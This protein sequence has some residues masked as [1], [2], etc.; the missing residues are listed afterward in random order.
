MTISSRKLFG[1]FG[2]N[3]ACLAMTD[4]TGLKTALRESAKLALLSLIVSGLLVPSVVAENS[5]IAFV[6]VNVVPMDRERV[7]SNQTV[8]V[9]KGRITA[10]GAAD[11][12]SVPAGA[13]RVEG[14]GKFLTPGLAEMHAHIPDPNSP[15]FVNDVL[16]LF[17]AN[18][19][20]T[21]RGM[22]GIPGQLALKQ[23]ANK[24]EMISPTL[25]LAGPGFSGNPEYGSVKT[26]EQA[27]QQ[28]RQQKAEGWD[29]LKVLPGF[30]VVPYDAMARTAKEVGMRF[31]GH[32][33]DGRGGGLMHALEMGQETIEHMDGYVAYLNGNSGVNESALRDVHP[34]DEAA[35][36]EV[37]RKTREA[38]VWICP[39]MAWHE[40]ST[41]WLDLKAVSSRPEL[42]YMPPQ[43]V[44]Q[45]TTGHKKRLA[46]PQFKPAVA[47]QIVENRKRILKGLHDGG[48]R[49]LLGT[50]TP[51]GFSVP[52][53]SI[54]REMKKMVEAGMRP[55]EVIKSGT[56]DVGLYFK[57]KDNFGTVEVG[58]RADL[59]L[60]DAN[61][62]EDVANI[63]RISGVM[64]RGSWLPEKDIRAGLDKIAR[65]HSEN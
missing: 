41:G 63:D 34:V 52:G 30:D 45:W 27:I 40:I 56:R 58:K 25:Y 12:T 64:V 43:L 3:A 50:D 5:P 42:K 8:I 28:V 29:L 55:Y 65:S 48:V 62:L 51:Q 33:P 23:R 10:V 4:F 31:V 53:F 54:H 57:D 22:L 32:V 20:T 7:L 1:C 39:T 13:V 18:G 49:I 46:N 17:V 6:H 14:G 19:I 11:K 44:S 21:A 38:G 35:L 60:V 59:I 9:E 61:P 37:V 2:R 16:F 26:A 47:K 15:Q 36:K 24:G